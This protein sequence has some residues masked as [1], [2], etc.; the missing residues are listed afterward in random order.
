[1]EL[2]LEAEIYCPSV[3]EEHNYVDKMPPTI[4]HG[5]RC[6][7]GSRKDKVYVSSAL[8]NNHCKTKHHLTW[9]KELNLNKINHYKENEE[10]KKTVQSQRIIISQLEKE[11]INKLRAIDFITQQL[12]S[13]TVSNAVE[14]LLDFH[15]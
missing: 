4:V 8:F 14:D 1:M 12:M 7:C 10:L 2:A 9:I 11:I 5:I 3:D 6:P 15:N 13:K